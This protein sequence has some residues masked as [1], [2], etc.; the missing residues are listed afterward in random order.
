MTSLR[1][2]ALA[3][4]AVICS[5]AAS[6]DTPVPQQKL[7]LW[8][9]TTTTS[10]Q[11]FSSLSCIDAASQAKMSA[12]GS[13][14]RQSKCKSSS[15][16]HNADGS[17]TST[18]TCEFEPG[19]VRTTHGMIRGDFNSKLSMTMTLD[20]QTKPEMAITMTYVGACK[21]GMKGGD[22]IMANGMKMNMIDGTMSGVPK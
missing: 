5:G 19:K 7:G 16:T 3:G 17:W 2:A 22:V 1:I 11:N 13:N 4:I 8:Q 18:S 6:A 14:I 20:G 9:S 12:F 21:P 10:G 15:I